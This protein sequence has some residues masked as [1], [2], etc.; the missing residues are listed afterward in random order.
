MSLPSAELLRR[1]AL[2]ALGALGH[3]LALAAL[4]EGALAIE[5]DVLQWEG[6]HGPVRGH[7]VIL[8]VPDARAAES[9]AARDA[10]VAAVAAAVALEPGNALADLQ[11]EPGAPPRARGSPYR[12]GA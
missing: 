9:P 12:D 3:P 7:R 8:Q 6:S 10:L 5:P 1:R 11:I 2:E 4:E